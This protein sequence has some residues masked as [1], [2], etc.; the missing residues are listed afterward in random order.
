MTRQEKKYKSLNEFARSQQDLAFK[1]KAKVN[2]PKGFEPGIRW[3]NKNKKG[4]IT[5]RGLKKEDDPRWDDYMIQWGFDPKKFRVKQD[6]VQF[7]C[8]DANYGKDENG[9][10][11]IQTLYYYK[12]DLELKSPEYEDVDYLFD[13]E[14]DLLKDFLCPVDLPVQHLTM[15]VRQ[16]L[17]YR[18]LTCLMILKAIS[19]ARLLSP[20]AITWISCSS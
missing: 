2:A 16:F 11:L 18:S 8:W 7:R 3:D 10:P 1:G 15:R 5:S 20:Q 12:C 4:S 14:S 17:H 6:T 9:D 13:F 19:S